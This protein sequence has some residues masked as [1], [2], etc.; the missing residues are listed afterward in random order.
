MMMKCFFFK[1]PL[2]KNIFST[3][4]N[5]LLSLL[6]EIKFY[7]PKIARILVQMEDRERLPKSK[8][9]LCVPHLDLLIVDN[10]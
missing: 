10:S 8:R 6:F 3:T 2:N 4:K 7:L 9:I 1:N 5:V